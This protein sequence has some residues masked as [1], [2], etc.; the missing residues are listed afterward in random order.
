M[1]LPAAF[2]E[3]D[4]QRIDALLRAHPLA[5]LVSG[6]GADGPHVSHVPLLREDA[7]GPGDRLIGHF[8]RANPHATAFDDGDVVLA[9]FR[10]PDAYVSPVWYAS[11]GVPTWN[12]AAVH[13][14]GRIRRVTDREALSA[15]IGRLAAAFEADVGEDWRWGGSGDPQA[16]K[17]DYI[18]GFE[19]AIERVEAKFKLSQNRSAEDR[20]KLAERL[21]AS[22]READRTVAAMMMENERTQTQK[23]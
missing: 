19:I 9:V 17:L 13:V 16:G 12:Y 18:V 2:R 7:G 14:H 22:P 3:E 6:S 15:L 21:A 23:E 10:G 5:L 20:H 4:P 11:P 8:A 1:Y